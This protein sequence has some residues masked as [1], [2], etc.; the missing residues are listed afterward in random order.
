[1]SSPHQSMNT[2]ASRDG[3]SLPER[4]Y[5]QLA[6][7]IGD[8]VLRLRGDC[9]TWVSPSFTAVTGWPAAEIVGKSLSALV[10]DED[11]AR[12]LAAHQALTVE[13][14]ALMSFR[15][16]RID[17]GSHWVEAHARCFSDEDHDLATVESMRVIDERI[18]LERD[19][20]RRATIDEL[21]GLLSRQE[22][23]SRLASPIDRRHPGDQVAVLFCDVDGLEAVNDT[24]GHRA[25]D[26]L[27]RHIGEGMHASIRSLDLA[28][29]IGG[30]EFVVLLNGVD[31]LD[32]ALAVAEKMRWAARQPLE[33]DGMH[34]HASL[35]I[36][37]VLSAATDD[38]SELLNQAD[39]AMYRAKRDGRDRV[40][41]IT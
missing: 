38:L 15:I 12:A 33:F 28:A 29:R 25:G 5:R 30:D 18:N 7:N 1:M 23:L 6:E 14:S 9:I 32:D 13:A 16:L 20:R 2:S 3:L 26:L 37:V 11:R 4:A 22:V 27:L 40:H 8:L 21:T 10:H 36:G 31:S 41:V 35:S 39:Q 34:I 19:L 17:G 24:H